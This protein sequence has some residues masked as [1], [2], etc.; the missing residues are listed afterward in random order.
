MAAFTHTP[1]ADQPQAMGA[2]W[3]PY[4]GAGSAG[5]A[6]MGRKGVCLYC[7]PH[8]ALAPR[9]L[10]HARAKRSTAPLRHHRRSAVPAHH[11]RSSTSPFLV[12]IAPP[13]PPLPPQTITTSRRALVR[14][15]FASPPPH[16][17]QST[18]GLVAHHGPAIPLPRR[19]PSPLVQHPAR[20]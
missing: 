11:R 19:P 20:V 13:P 17:H 9:S 10:T 1:M 7:S 15:H 16:R 18:A 6:S 14:P 12:P 2:T 3:R 5:Q 8:F 4:T